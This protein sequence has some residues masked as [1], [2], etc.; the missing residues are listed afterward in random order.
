MKVVET[1]LSKLVGLKALSEVLPQFGWQYD[2]M[3]GRWHRNGALLREI[4]TYCNTT[5]NLVHVILSTTCCVV[6]THRL[7]READ[8]RAIA[9]ASILTRHINRG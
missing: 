9:V 8:L 3:I 4:I 5:T 2:S 6:D 1:S 7:P